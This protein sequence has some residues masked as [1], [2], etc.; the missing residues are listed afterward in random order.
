MNFTSFQCPQQLPI[1]V[2]STWPAGDLIGL[3]GS[4]WG[5]WNGVKFSCWGRWNRVKF[6]CWGH[7]TNWN[8][9]VGGTQME[10][11]FIPGHLK[12]FFIEMFFWSLFCQKHYKLDMWSKN[13]KSL[14]PHFKH[15]LHCY[16]W[17]VLMSLCMICLKN[18][19]NSCSEL[20]VY[21][22]TMDK[23]CQGLQPFEVHLYLEGLA[24]SWLQCKIGWGISTSAL[25]NLTQKH[26]V[27]LC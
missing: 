22:P 8:L 24:C 21:Q 27:V 4:C 20:W 11:Y 9:V 13:W 17:Q 10:W 19:T 16:N 7:Q 25:W 18:F 12:I 26:F 6:V 1:K 2:H 5:H 14:H 15:M 23:H 3:I